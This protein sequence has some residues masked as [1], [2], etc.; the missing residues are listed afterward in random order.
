M[1]GKEN[2]KRNLILFT[3][4]V[5]GLAALA[6]VI[7]PFTVAPNAEPGAAGLG[8][9]LWIA[10]P[11][12]VTLLFRAFGGDGWGDL[13][14]RPNFNGNHLWWWVS[15]LIFPVI[16]TLTILLGTVTGGLVLN[17]NR[18]G[19]FTGALL[20]GLIW[21]LVKNIPEE[22]A[23][24][25]YLAPKLYSLNINIWLAHAIVGLIWVSGICRLSWSFG[26]TSRRT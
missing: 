2:A 16:I 12:V 8:Q 17:T 14:L 19:D 18:I 4:S 1:M 26:P 3:V 20:A 9:L 24:R 11:L 5:L 10:A 21:A 23:W 7:E 6:G 22:F 25:G 15:I 13:G